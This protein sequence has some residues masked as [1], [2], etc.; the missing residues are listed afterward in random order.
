VSDR[1]VAWELHPFLG[2]WG[3]GYVGAERF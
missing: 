3:H 2:F 1:D